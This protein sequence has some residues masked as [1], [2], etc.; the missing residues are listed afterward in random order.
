LYDPL[1]IIA[2]V[3]SVASAV[4]VTIT[5]GFDMLLGYRESGETSKRRDEINRKLRDEVK[6]QE[7][8]VLKTIASEK[9][10]EKELE[11]LVDLGQSAFYARSIANRLL[12]QMT[13][14]MGAALGFVAITLVVFL[15]TLFQGLN[16]DLSNLTATIPFFFFIALGFG[17]LYVT[18]KMLQG[19]YTLRERFLRLCENTTLAYC[20]ELVEE[21]REKSLL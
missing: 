12:E 11:T 10:E 16:S 8:E 2:L 18:A 17:T 20:K 5:K 9:D 13:Q 21:L 6:K 4:F 19:Y 14:R 7:Q 15:L 1:A 3:I